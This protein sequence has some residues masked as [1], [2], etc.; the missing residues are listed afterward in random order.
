MLGSSLTTYGDKKLKYP[1]PL[2]MGPF[3]LDRGKQSRSALVNLFCWMREF[4]E[5]LWKQFESVLRL[6]E[7]CSAT[8]MDK[9]VFYSAQTSHI[10][11]TKEIEES[12]DLGGTPALKPFKDTRQLSPRPALCIPLLLNFKSIFNRSFNGSLPMKNIITYLR[13]LQSLLR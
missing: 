13:V 1:L 10:T 12:I 3:A 6:Y 2:P 4:W 7:G 5:I 8:T 11:G 9:S